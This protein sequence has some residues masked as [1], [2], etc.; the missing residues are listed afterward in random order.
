V[1]QVNVRL[2]SAILLALAGHKALAQATYSAGKVYNITR[3]R[4]EFGLNVTSNWSC[5]TDIPFSP[6]VFAPPRDNS[7]TTSLDENKAYMQPLRDFEFRLSTITTDYLRSSTENL[8]IANCA[9]SWL[10]K[11]AVK[12][13]MVTAPAWTPNDTN[14]WQL[15]YERAFLGASIA[16][17][18]AAVAA[19][20]GLNPTVKQRVSAWIVRTAD[21]THS[22]SIYRE[23]NDLT[24]RYNNIYAWMGLHMLTAGLA[25]GNERLKERGVYSFRKVAGQ[26]RSDGLISTELLRAPEGKSFWYHNFALRPMFM[27]AETMANNGVNLYAYKAGPGHGTLGMA[28]ARIVAA[29]ATNLA[30]FPDASGQIS[31][32]RPAYFTSDNTGQLDWMEIFRRRFHSTDARSAPQLVKARQLFPL[33]GVVG[34]VIKSR[35]GPNGTIAYGVRSP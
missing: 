19:Q 30:N 27:M 26:I 22:F 29:Y 3:I 17:H 11:W 35:C 32:S 21:L 5:R 24:Y 15:Q 1:F 8:K 25:T 12:N 13:F 2:L 6:A 28:G 34:G 33:V 23:R 16:Q 4:N 9:L 31:S 20:P 10:D 14:W 7:A 18:F